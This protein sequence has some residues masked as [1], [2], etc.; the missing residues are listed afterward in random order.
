MNATREAVAP[1]L[2]RVAATLTMDNVR[3]KT[4]MP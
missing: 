3:A 1:N 4:H 2:G